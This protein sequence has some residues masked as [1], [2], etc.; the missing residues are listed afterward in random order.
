MRL[1]G[2]DDERVRVD[3]LLSGARTGRAGV[4]AYVGEPGIGKSALLAWARGRAD[5]FAQLA[6]TGVESESEIG[7]GGLLDLFGAHPGV[8]RGAA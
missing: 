7:Y 5:G 4:L 8:A 2:R 3:R 1:H 6:L